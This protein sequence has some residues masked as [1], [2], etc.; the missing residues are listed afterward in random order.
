MASVV[1][2]SSRSPWGG[3]RCEHPDVGKDQGNRQGC[4]KAWTTPA[5]PPGPSGQGAPHD[6]VPPVQMVE[7]MDFVQGN[8]SLL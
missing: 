6:P 3:A 4:R 7:G 5:E 2:P 8:G 1:R